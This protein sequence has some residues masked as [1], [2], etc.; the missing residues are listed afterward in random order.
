MTKI[1]KVIIN[2]GVSREHVSVYNNH[3][4]HVKPSTCKQI[5]GIIHTTSIVSIVL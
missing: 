2:A 4:Y 5:K 1:Q 3:N